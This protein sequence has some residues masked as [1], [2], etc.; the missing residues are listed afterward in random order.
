MTDSLAKHHRRRQATYN[1]YIVIHTSFSNALKEHTRYSSRCD[2]LPELNGSQAAAA[3]YFFPKISNRFELSANSQSSQPRSGLINLINQQMILFL[4][5]PRL[6]TNG[7][8]P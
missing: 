1:R 2:P 4:D 6:T 5:I 3:A 8:R 7:W